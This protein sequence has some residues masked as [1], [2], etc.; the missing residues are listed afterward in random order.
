MYDEREICSVGGQASFWGSV[1]KRRSGDALPAGG[2]RPLSCVDMERD[3]HDPTERETVDGGRP[4]TLDLL[5]RAQ[6]G[7]DLAVESLLERYLPRLRRW[8]SG[9]L[10]RWARELLDTDDLIQETLMRTADRLEAFEP[11]GEGAFAA[12]LRQAL[13][14]RI[15]DELRRLE[16]RPAR[17][18]LDSNRADAGASPLEEAIGREAVESYER[19]LER[20]DAHEREAIVLRIE[21]GLSWAAV[22]EA[23]GKPSP[24]AARVA[25]SRALLRVAQEMDHGAA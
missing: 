18:E 6:A 22:A 25:V 15:A 20:L 10:P 3:G 9:R 11:R 1:G 7:D 4:S 21:L 17:T 24:D 23:M 2:G 19:A 16:R 12:Y 8:A 14:H 5:R 13:R